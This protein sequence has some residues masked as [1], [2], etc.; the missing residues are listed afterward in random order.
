MTKVTV[1][2]NSKPSVEVL[3]KSAQVF[4]VTD[5]RG[6]VIK[7]KK[8]ATLAQ[9]R[10]VEIMGDSARNQTY[11][12][13]VLPLI[14]VVG[15]DDQA[16]PQPRTKLEVESLITRLDD[17]GIEAVMNGVTANFGTS[18]AAADKEAIKN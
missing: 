13:M 4:E 15:I 3:N 1:E 11:M 12:G 10:I 9:Y 6:R 14:Y 5:V 18:S 8:P 7:L 16:L 17:D 2:E